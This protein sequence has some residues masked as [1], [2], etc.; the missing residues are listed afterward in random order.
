MEGKKTASFLEEC[1]KNSTRH[2]SQ[3]FL[4]ASA[5]FNSGLQYALKPPDQKLCHTCS[6][7]LRFPV[8]RKTCALCE[9]IYCR[10]CSSRDLALTLPD[11]LDPGDVG[12]EIAQVGVR[13]LSKEEAEEMDKNSNTQTGSLHGAC[14]QRY[15]VCH[16]CREHVQHVM[17]VMNF[18]DKLAQ[19]QAELVDLQEQIV[20]VLDDEHVNLCLY[21]KTPL[22]QASG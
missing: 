19:L 14:V 3:R 10:N 18:N 15:R 21:S 11:D 16:D 2:Y 8:E 13:V 22:R 4:T 6:R 7:L 17:K 5:S 9:E 20:A 1:R 12:H